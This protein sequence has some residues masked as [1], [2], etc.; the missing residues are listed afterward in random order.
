VDLARAIDAAGIARRWR[1]EMVG[2]LGKGE[3]IFMS[4]DMG[5]DTIAGDEHRRYLLVRDTRDGKTSLEGMSVFTR[6][7][8]QN[9]LLI[10]L[11][12]GQGAMKFSLEHSPTVATDFRFSLDIIDQVLDNTAKVKAALEE[13]AA[14]PI[15]PS[16][17]EEV[18]AQV[19]PNPRKGHLLHSF[20]RIDDPA[21]FDPATL[22][23]L[24]KMA[25]EYEYRRSL[26]IPLRQAVQARY[27]V[28]CRDFPQIAYTG[29]GVLNAV[30]EVADH[31]RAGR[32]SMAAI[33]GNR[34][35]EKIRAYRAVRAFA[36]VAEALDAPETEDI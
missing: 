33:Y 23:R 22:S 17:M 27:D 34:A 30:T 1:P 35:A 7:V 13:T 29:L 6:V 12:E 10:A 36:G 18:W 15:P 5:A 4:F 25:E 2:V 20:E 26:V 19:Y 8:C 31:T 16:A 3:T 32:G 9:T 11:A 24:E 21:R 28:L 14:I